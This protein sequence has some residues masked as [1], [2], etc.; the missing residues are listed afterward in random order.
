[1]CGR[2]KGRGSVVV[3]ESDG[4]V[5]YSII[6][7]PRRISR[8]SLAPS[9]R[10]GRL[11]TEW[12]RERDPSRN[13]GADGKTSGAPDRNKEENHIDGDGGGR[14]RPKTMASHRRGSRQMRTTDRRQPRSLT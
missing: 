5:G 8:S 14:P 2:R 11:P 6:N 4:K 12:V 9:Q 13:D 3:K 10:G 1:M 7:D